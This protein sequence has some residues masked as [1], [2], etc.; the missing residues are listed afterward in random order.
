MGSRSSTTCSSRSRRTPAPLRLTQAITS[1]EIERNLASTVVQ[2]TPPRTTYTNAAK[3]LL[4][5]G[6]NLVGV[7]RDDSVHMDFDDIEVSQGDLLVYIGKSR[8]KPEEMAAL[9]RK[10]D[11]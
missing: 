1:N 6:V 2:S 4:D 8:L 7:I 11:R 5:H 9:L 3:V 10:G